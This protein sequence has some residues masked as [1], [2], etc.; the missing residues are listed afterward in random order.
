M[1]LFIISCMEI[2]EV[3]TAAPELPELA[4]MR[5][6]TLFDRV[7]VHALRMLKVLNASPRLT[8]T[9]QLECRWVIQTLR[10]AS[11]EW[12]AGDA[13][14]RVS[15][16]DAAQQLLR[17]SSDLSLWCEARLST[18]LCQ[19]VQRAS[20]NRSGV[21]VRCL[22]VAL[23]FEV[24]LGATLESSR[25]GTWLGAPELLQTA[26]NSTFQLCCL[27][28]ELS[29]LPEVNDPL[30]LVERIRTVQASLI[31]E[32]P[33]PLPYTAALDDEPIR[34][35]IPDEMLR[36]T[37]EARLY[38]IH[39]LL[40]WQL[41]DADLPTAAASGQRYFEAQLYFELEQWAERLLRWPVTPGQRHWSPDDLGP[42]PEM[43]DWS[44]DAMLQILREAK[45]LE[46]F[47]GRVRRGETKA[48][49]WFWSGGPEP[50]KARSILV[51]IATWGVSTRPVAW[52]KEPNRR[53][54]RPEWL[55]LRNLLLYRTMRLLEAADQDA[56]YGAVQQERE[57]RLPPPAVAAELRWL[58]TLLT[59]GATEEVTLQAVQVRKEA[60][61]EDLYQ[62]ASLNLNQALT[63]LPAF[64][65]QPQCAAL[66]AVL[67][68]SLLELANLTP[69]DLR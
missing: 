30:T 56:E 18:W 48:A 8:E 10:A 20:Q 6:F 36:L 62:R 51:E 37:W 27:L 33:T 41:S 12:N 14:N 52:P 19:A 21:A 7:I 50:L 47:Q 26:A 34:L 69:G 2:G 54:P 43:N 11:V 25:P 61:V 58:G 63:Y 13:P 16:E 29:T 9:Q 66:D 60:Q 35:N 46:V 55:L 17:T 67:G 1:Q 45:R 65:A 64:T 3:A 59:E 23:V 42:L 49:R 57:Y 68:R 4:A 44:E 40:Q 32:D 39:W 22:A 31:A 15:L 24:W 5:A 28:G 38:W 53:W